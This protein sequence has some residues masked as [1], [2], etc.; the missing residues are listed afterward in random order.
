MK[1][2]I[3]SIFFA[4]VLVLSFSLVTAV[5]AAAATTW[6]VDDDGP[7]DFATIQAAIDAASNGDT[8]IVA[9]GTY[10]N[11]IWDSSALPTPIP[12]GYRITKSITLLGAQAGNDP[13]GSTDRG[14]ESILVRTNGLPYSLYASDITIDGF[15]IGSSDPN[16]GGRL[17]IADIADRVTIKNC[18]I[19]NTPTASS[20]HGVYIYPGAN[21]ALV[22]YNTLSNTGWEAI[23][24]WQVSGAVISHN[25]I[26]SSGEHAIQMMGHAG[27]DNEITYNHISGIVGKNA[28]QYWGGPGATISHNVIDGENTMFDG[29]WL[30]AAADGST[31]SN[32]QITDTIYAGINVRGD[33]VD[34]TVTYNDVSGCGTGIE[35]HVGATGALVNYNNIAGNS[36]GV[37]NYDSATL[38]ATY[39]WWGH[40]SGPSGEAGRTSNKGKVIGKGDAVSANVDWDPWLPQHVNHTPHHP[41]PPGLLK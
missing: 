31:V 2:K 13:A 20:G 12:Y 3:F 16:T 15:M 7:A 14:G 6:T 4:L 10:T 39:N 38:D 33:C 5:P 22:E 30:D 9:A 23:A 18:I 36:W 1:R 37:S 8:I 29:I 27:S 19:Q 32:N 25:Y 17:I 28:I 41:V 35:T 34:A 24:S 26:S 40:A 21:N 11:D